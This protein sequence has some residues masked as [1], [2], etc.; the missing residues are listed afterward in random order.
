MPGLSG[1]RTG[2]RCHRDRGLTFTC[3]RIVANSAEAYY[4]AGMA[5]F[6]YR[7]PSTGLNVQGFVANDPTE[8]EAEIYEA[9]TCTACTRLHFVNPKTGKVLGIGEE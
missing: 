2:R 3:A 6:L 4:R 8:S 1:A 9:I 5:P 7:C